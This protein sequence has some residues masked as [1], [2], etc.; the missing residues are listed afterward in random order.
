M[1]SKGKIIMH[2]PRWKSALFGV[3]LVAIPFSARAETPETISAPTAER[4][5]SAAQ[6][7]A[8][9]MPPEQ[10]EAMVEQMI[11]A[12]MANILPS[13]KNSLEKQAALSN[14]ELRGVFDR[15]IVRQ[16]ELAISQLKAEMPKLVEAMSRAYARRFTTAQMDEMHSFFRTPTGQIYVRESMSI[17]SDPDVAEWQRDSMTKSMDKLPE[18]LKALQ[19]ELEEKL[20]RPVEE[21]KA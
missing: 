7:M 12:M 1:T 2:M 14:P 6:L 13:I 8:A 16:Q 17:M 9:M 11:T 20:G 10:R 4:L 15:F 19:Q 21:N 3:A 5:A 18:E